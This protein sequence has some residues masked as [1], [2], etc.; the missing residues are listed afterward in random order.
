[1]SSS[2]ERDSNLGLLLPDDKECDLET[3]EKITR[4]TVDDQH[5]SLASTCLQ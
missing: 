5:T 4:I 3:T 2:N 1:M